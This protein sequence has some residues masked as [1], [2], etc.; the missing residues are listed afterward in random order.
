MAI[1]E[2][3]RTGGWVRGK[4]KSSLP[5]VLERTGNASMTVRDVMRKENIKSL[6]I[7]AKKK[8]ACSHLFFL[9]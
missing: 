8:K 3:K 2:I 4:V 7:Y 1:M 9:V 5:W 6:V